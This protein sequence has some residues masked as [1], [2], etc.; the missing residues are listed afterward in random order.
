MKVRALASAPTAPPTAPTC[1]VQ[2]AHQLVPGLANAVAIVAVDHEDQA[3]GVLEVVPPQGANLEAQ[4]EH[5]ECQQCA[6][7]LQAEAGTPCPCMR[8]TATLDQLHTLSWPPTSHTVKLMFLYSTV[9]TL[10]LR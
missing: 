2:H 1:L 8:T 9:S 4:N 6:S 5:R 10:N 3:L 7:T